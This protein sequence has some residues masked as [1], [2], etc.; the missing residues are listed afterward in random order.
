MTELELRMSVVN[1]AKNWIGYCEADGS[2]RT[3]IDLYNSHRPL[4]RG[5]AVSYSDAWCATFV[6]AVAV[7]TGLTD[8]IPTECS[9][10]KQVLLFTALDCWQEGDDYVPQ[11]GDIIYYDWNDDGQGDNASNPDHVGIVVSVEGNTITVVEGNKNNTVGYRAVEVNGRYIRGYGLPNYKSYVIDTPSDWASSQ[12]EKVKVA[13]V[14]DGTRPADAL[15]RQELA[16]VLE[17]VGLI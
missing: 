10:P 9:C 1:A 14:L 7:Q 15:T 11:A 6:S 5:Y 16:V 17:R 13:G 2:H 12:W 4:A 3:I 8:I